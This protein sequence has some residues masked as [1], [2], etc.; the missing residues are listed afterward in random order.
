[1]L[2][3]GFIITGPSGST[4]TVVIRG[5]GPSL[6]VNGT[7]I[8][9][10]LSDPSIELHRPDG[11][12]VTNDNWRDAANAG[13]IP[14]ILQPSDEREAVILTTL[15]P[16]AYSAIVKGAHDETGVGLV[17]VYDLEQGSPAKLA[18][19]STRGLVQTG[20]N[21]MIGGFIITG[22]SGSTTRVILR[23]LGPSLRVNGVPVPGRLADPL[24]ELHQPDGSIVTNDNWRDAANGG[25][26]PVELQPTDDREAAIL[27][28]LAPGAYTAIVQGAHGETGVALVEAYQLDP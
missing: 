14:V 7:P 20:D 10:R 16:G 3:G 28:T 22:P 25:Q 18:N 23:G 13:E 19:I 1:M 12:I 11:S 6:N 15:A 2:I 17:E 24:I 21:V 27:A 4:K 26:I 8:T 5:L 9:G